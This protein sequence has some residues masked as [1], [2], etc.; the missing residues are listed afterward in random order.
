MRLTDV[1]LPATLAAISACTCPDGRVDTAAFAT[2]KSHFQ[3]IDACIASDD[4]C[5]S[6]CRAA[7]RLEPDVAIVKCVITSA[8]REGANL[9][10]TYIEPIDCGIGRKPGGYH[11]PPRRRGAGAWLANVATLEAA[12][13]T[14]FAR[15]ARALARFEAPGKLVEASRRAIADELAHA[16]MMGAL[17]RRYGARVEAPDV[18]PAE[19]PALAQLAIEN[20]AEGQVGETF[21]ALVAA[22]QARAAAD[23]DVRAVFAQIAADEARHA[24]LAHHLALWF[25]RRLG[26]RE[27]NAVARARQDAIA[28]VIA[29]SCDMGLAAD[30]RELLGVPAPD[31]LRAAAMQLFASV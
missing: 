8:S 4:N 6:L 2:R 14:A 26:W 30:E 1:V 10:V 12:S 7:L 19:E 18:A 24:A 16:A 5:E 11:A 13:V 25:E 27:R 20:A 22:C 29:T 17:A 21:G 15:L 3:L 23:P 31:R 28:R 9:D